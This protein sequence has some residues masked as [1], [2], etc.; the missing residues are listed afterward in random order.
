MTNIILDNLE[1]LIANPK[2]LFIIGCVF[3]VNGV[4]AFTRNVLLLHINKLNYWVKTTISM[5][6]PGLYSLIVSVVYVL[7][8]F[9]VCERIVG[10]IIL[11]AF[12]I[13][14]LSIFLYDVFYKKWK[15]WCKLIKGKDK[16]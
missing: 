14:T 11:Y 12:V 13:Y 15:E 6:L 8:I 3:T 7:T 1:R 9:G 10:Y 2:L 16:C 4:S 5:S